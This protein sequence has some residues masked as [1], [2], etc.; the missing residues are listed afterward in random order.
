MKKLEITHIT[1]YTYSDSAQDSVNEVRLTPLTDKRQSC[2][3]HTITTEPVSALFTYSDYFH[4]QVHAFTV[5]KIHQE[6]TIKMVSTVVTRNNAYPQRPSIP[7]FDQKAERFSDTFQNEYAEYLLPTG[8]TA[9]TPE[10]KAYAD[11]IPDDGISL[12]HLIAAIGATIYFDFTYDPSAT[13]VQ[14][15]ALETLKLRRGVC[16]DY[17]HLMIAICRDK[18]IPARYVSGY[19]FVGDLQGGNADFTQASHAWV[20]CLIPGAGWL[21]FDPTNNNEIN[22]RYV[23]LAHGRDYNDIVPVKG[24]YRGSGTQDLDV[25]VDVKLLE[26]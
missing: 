18:G 17:S 19:H 11:A 3:H 2:Y 5:N 14:T 15:T 1:R 24:I 21:G 25:F 20:E 26:A 12:H 16:Q 7:S 23:K 6:L 22:W 13:S 8:Y 10:V 9:L 4:N